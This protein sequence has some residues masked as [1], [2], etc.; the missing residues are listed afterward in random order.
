MCITSKWKNGVPDFIKVTMLLCRIDMF[1]F[2]IYK[3]G[4]WSLNSRFISRY[5]FDNYVDRLS[6]KQRF[7]VKTSSNNMTLVLENMLDGHI[8]IIGNRKKVRYK[9]NIT[10]FPWNTF[11]LEENIVWYI[12]QHYP[13]IKTEMNG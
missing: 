8:S 4:D 13:H 9:Y 1:F 12:H 6:R 5:F 11:L 10:D 3:I 2:F 7:K